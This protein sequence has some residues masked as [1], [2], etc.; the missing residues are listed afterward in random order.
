MA[1]MGLL[2]AGANAAYNASD[3]AADPAYSSGWRP[4]S[5]GGNGFGPWNFDKDP[6][7][8]AIDSWPGIDV[9]HRS[10][11]VTAEYGTSA[12]RSFNGGPLAAGQTVQVAWGLPGTNAGNTQV[13]LLD[14]ANNHI[15]QVLLNGGWLGVATNTV[16]GPGA[17][18]P[19]ATNGATVVASL[20]LT[21]TNAL[22][23]SLVSGTNSISFT[24]VVF[25][26]SISAIALYVEGVNDPTVPGKTA[27]FNSL[28]VSGGINQ[29]APPV[30]DPPGGTLTN[31]QTVAMTTTT[32]GATIRYT[33]DG[34]L[35]TSETGIVYSGPA[36]FD[37]LKPM[38]LQAI[39]CKTNMADSPVISGRYHPATPMAVGNNLEQVVDWSA[40]WPFV[41]VF[42][43]TRPW[44][45]R[46]VDD[47]IGRSTWDTGFGS[48]I[49]VDTNGWPTRAPFPVNGTNQLVHTVMSSLNEAGAYRFIYEGSGSLYIRWSPGGSADL[50]ATG[51]VQSF[52]FATTT[53]DTQVLVEIHTSATNDYLRNFHIVQTNYLDTYATQ[54][55]HPLFLQ[56]LQPFKCLRLMQWGMLD[57]MGDTPLSAWT[58]RTTPSYYTQFNARGVALEHMVELWNTLQADAWLCIPHAADD[59]YVRQAA[60]LLR[61]RLNPN[62]RLYLE[63]SNETWNWQYSQT[64]YVLNQGVSLALDSDQ[65]AAAQKY[66]ALRSAQIWN[67]FQEV[68]GSAASSRLVKVLATFS[69]WTVVTDLRIAGLLDTRINP[70]GTMPDALAV[71]PYFGRAF[72]PADLPP[73]APYPTVDDILTN[74]CVQ[75]IAEQRVQM[76]LHKTIADAHGWRL[77]CYEGGQTFVGIGGAEA[78]TN[79]TAILTAANRDPRMF[80]I[81]TQYL[82]MLKEQGVDLFV[83]YSYCGNWGRN[84]NWGALEVQ[85]QPPHTA[86]KYSALV[87]WMVANPAPVPWTAPVIHGLGQAGGVFAFSWSAAAGQVYRIQYKDNLNQADWLALGSNVTANGPVQTA[88]DLGTNSQ[89]F[90]R[91][92]RLR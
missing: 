84:G 54:P 38:T 87:D 13:R 80:T 11:A 5:N 10:W 46:S 30:L 52:S 41:D 29:V 27:Y 31:G 82:D 77:V 28:S 65:Y 70:A 40:S 63:Y 78:D 79:L 35:P 81:Y 36:Q 53:P 3:N 69:G 24:N 25:T 7:Q 92:I 47:A 37:L 64:Y 60:R 44:M 88:A 71:A 48:L 73:N 8:Y 4:A 15:I 45:T 72:S 50:I 90:Y 86:P 12:I 56:R 61:D 18:V 23:L 62:L 43:R 20:T 76:G 49:P 58:N 6:S 91:V 74:L 14:S 34:S 16:W 68:F 9:D 32:A 67:I 19:W 42:K 83:N 39:A 33:I 1:A 75:S 55:F 57:D 89:R 2:A 26:G 51:G 85:D 66:V 21:R 22:E 17:G 59:D